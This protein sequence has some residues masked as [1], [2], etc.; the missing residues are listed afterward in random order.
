LEQRLRRFHRTVS[1]VS[2]PVEPLTTQLA[3]VTVTRWKSGLQSRRHRLKR[4]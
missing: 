1:H 4:H 3:A 2:Q